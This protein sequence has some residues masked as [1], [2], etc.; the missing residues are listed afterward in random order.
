MGCESC[1]DSNDVV[2]LH[3]NWF[4]AASVNYFCCCYTAF[5]VIDIVYKL[6]FVVLLL[7]VMSDLRF[8]LF[9]H[10]IQICSF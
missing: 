2:M 10:W 6:K 5:C 1:C 7:S 3:R 9:V 4:V 8:N